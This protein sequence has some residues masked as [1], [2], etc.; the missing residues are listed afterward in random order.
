VQLPSLNG[1]WLDG[2][3]PAASGWL[4]GSQLVPTQTHP[5]TGGVPTHA[6]AMP[7]EPPPD[8]L[9]P[10]ELPPDE[11]PLDEP[12]PDE[13]VVEPP[14]D[15]PAPAAKG[16]FGGSQLVP[17]QT[18]PA[19]GG[20]PRHAAPPD[21]DPPAEELPDEPPDDPLEDPPAG[22]PPLLAARG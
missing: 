9:P 6:G 15:E 17:T 2:T 13:P 21:C 18:Q 3:P 7:G 4:G 14:E 8:E 5:E 11:P 20:L 12:P 19:T 10:D 1:T 22:D 16:W